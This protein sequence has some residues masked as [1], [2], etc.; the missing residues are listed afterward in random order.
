MSAQRVVVGVDGSPLSFVALDAAAIESQRRT[1][2]LEVV[3]CVADLDEAGPILR[4]AASRVAERHPGLAVITTAVV[5]DPA[6]ALV[7]RSRDAALTV[8]GSRDIGGIA[9]LMLHSVSHRVA[10]R[11]DVP[12]LVVRGTN[13]RRTTQHP[14][15]GAV[16][17][18]LE[19]DDDAGAALF[20]FG[21]AELRHTHLDIGTGSVRSTPCRALIAATRDAELVVIAAHR[22]RNR[23]GVQLS[24]VARALL[25]HAYCP[26]AIVPVP[27]GQGAASGEGTSGPDEVAGPRRPTVRSQPAA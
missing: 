7:E 21:E 13:A 16:L 5:G 12:L 3:T 19:D 26:V 11:T 18:C 22:Q 1:A 6:D 10:T 27:E 17:L 9:G 20:A 2:D 8:V 4:V 23:L 14:G 15:G 24:P 25:H